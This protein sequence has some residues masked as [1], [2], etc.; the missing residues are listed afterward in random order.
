[1]RSDK[2]LAQYLIE[3]AKA[4]GINI[5]ED[6]AERLCSMLKD[7]AYF[8]HDLL[9]SAEYFFNAPQEYN[10]Q[11]IKKFW[12]EDSANLLGDICPVIESIEDFSSKNI[13]DIV[14]KHIETIGIGFGKVMN[15]LRLVLVGECKGPHL[16]DIIA[17][18]GKEETLKR[19]KSG[20]ASIKL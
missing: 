2:E 9:S 20:I 15:P 17:E 18:I 10:A 6:K 11:N 14:S 12:K 8:T 13:E 5:S 4:E 7:R 1:M 3:D 16:F 19:I